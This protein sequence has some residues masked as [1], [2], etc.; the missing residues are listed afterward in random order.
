MG[1]RDFY[2][3][4]SELRERGRQ[5]MELQAL[6]ARLQR[7]RK[8]VPGPFMA[9]LEH[10]A[11]ADAAA[12]AATTTARRR[13]QFLRAVQAAA[14]THATSIAP[15]TA[16]PTR[17]AASLVDARCAARAAPSRRTRS[18]R[19]SWTPRTSGCA[20]SSRGERARELKAALA[21][22]AEELG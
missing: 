15:P 7:G 22:M 18:T 4:Q 14:A 10:T 3:V 12:A 9:S 19:R 6:S 2:K 17:R 21:G 1:W 11:V 16:P 5:V 20:A 13:A 8:A